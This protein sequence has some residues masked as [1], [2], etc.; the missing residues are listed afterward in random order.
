MKREIDRDAAAQG[1]RQLLRA[2][3][4]EEREG[5]EKTPARVVKAF[6]EM[7][8]G[9]DGDPGELLA[10]T[11]D[12]SDDEETRGVSYGGVV[13][14]R[15]IDFAS[16]CEHHLLPFVGVAHVAYLPAADGRVVGLSKLARLVHLYARRLQCQERLTAQVADALVTHLRAQGVLVVVRS[17]H[18]CM[19]LR[20]VKCHE[21]E[22]LTSEVRGAFLHSPTLR[23]EVMGLIGTP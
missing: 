2:L 11:F 16:T 4:V 8:S 7:L 14:L 9:Y 5:I 18:Q 10:T 19:S 1:V 17:R 13:L 23:A 12:M 6:E 20:G 15:G 3:G 22:M 21:A